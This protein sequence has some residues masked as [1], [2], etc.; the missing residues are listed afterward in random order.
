MHIEFPKNLVIANTPY[1]ISMLLGN[2]ESTVEPEDVS[3]SR[4]P[5]PPYSNM[6]TPSEGNKTFNQQ[7]YSNVRYD[8][9][10]DTG[11]TLNTIL[12]IC[13]NRKYF[14]EL[15]APR[16]KIHHLKNMK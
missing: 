15:R 9:N 4:T 7:P 2:N 3:R 5:P 12:G 1:E 6:W 11:K 14:Q 8:D 16:A 10:R 13:T